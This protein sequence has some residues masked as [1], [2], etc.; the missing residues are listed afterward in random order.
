MEIRRE[1][2]VWEGSRKQHRWGTGETSLPNTTSYKPKAK[3]I[4]GSRQ[5]LYKVRTNPELKEGNLMNNDLKMN[6][7]HY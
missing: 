6:M 4:S 1:G 2:A 5:P 7:M 3:E